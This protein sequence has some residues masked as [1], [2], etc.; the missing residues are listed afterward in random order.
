MSDTIEERIAREADALEH[1]WRANPRWG[2]VERHY[3]AEDVI[4]LRGSFLVDQTI[5]RLGAERLWELVN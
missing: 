3:S 1:D 5:A 2:G 4:R